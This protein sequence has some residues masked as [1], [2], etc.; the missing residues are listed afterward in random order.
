MNI[1]KI[2]VATGEMKV[3]YSQPQA[4]AGSA[5][6]TAGDLVFWGDQNRRL[7]A[8]DAD[9]GKV[10]WETVVGGMVMNSTITYAVNGKQYVMVFTGEGQSVIGRPARTDAED[11]CRRRCA[12]TTRSSSSRCRKCSGICVRLAGA[13]A[14][15]G[16]LKRKPEEGILCARGRRYRSW[17]RVWPWPSCAG[18]LQRRL[19]GARAARRRQPAECRSGRY[20]ARD[21]RRHFLFDGPGGAGA[22]A[23]RLYRRPH[24]ARIPQRAARRHARQGRH[25]LFR[26]GRPRRPAHR[27]PVAAGRRPGGGRRRSPTRSRARPIGAPCSPRS[28]ARCNS[29][30][31]CSTPPAINGIRR[32]IDVS[33]DGANNSGPLLVPVRDDVLA[34]GITINGLPIMLKQPQAWSLDIENL[35]IYY[36]DCVIGGP[37][38]FVIPIQRARPVQGGDPQQARAGD[39][40]PHAGGMRQLS[41]RRRAR[42]VFPAPSAR[43][44]AG[45]AGAGSWSF[46]ADQRTARCM[47]NGG[48]RCADLPEALNGGSDMMR[49]AIF[50]VAALA[51][52]L[53]VSAALA[54]QQ[55][56][57]GT[58]RVSGTI[59]RVDGNTVHGKGSDGGAITLKLADNVAI[60]AVMKAT[61]ADIKPGDYVG[62]GAV[63]QADGS[64]KAVELRIFPR[65]QADGGHFYEGWP[66]AANGTMTNGFVQPAG[67]VG[68]TSPAPAIQA[69]WSNTRRA[70]SGLSSQRTRMSCATRSAART[71]SRPARPS[72]P[73]RRP[74]S[75]TAP[76]PPRPSASA[77][78]APGR[79]ERT[80]VGAV[81]LAGHACNG[82]SRLCAVARQM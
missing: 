42:R 51:A 63:P 50:S 4:S 1:G 14:A 54:Q 44:C 64:Q 20:R 56:P 32:V 47:E 11:R 52:A 61:F 62:T 13:R 12:A 2:D 30:S 16:V 28:R 77:E 31:R 65:P 41:R 27:D 80:R 15:P 17:R 48:F 75:L 36:E 81:N 69:S 3:L 53:T 37:G 59:E 34:A 19:R 79:S 43:R 74:S 26:M 68:A 76:T 22:A 25:H 29:P 55:Q 7:R 6:V 23:R 58:Q 66:G 10:L 35:D 9:D 70:R 73:M 78:T 49:T 72:G 82:R 38:A 5:L 46:Q 60:T 45:S 67:T 71:T 21:R 8:F 33:G 18:G 39:R 40:R 57:P 24:L